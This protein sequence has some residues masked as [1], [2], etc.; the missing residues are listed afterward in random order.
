MKITTKIIWCLV[1]AFLAGTNTSVAA[2]FVV[3]LVQSPA[4]LAGYEGHLTACIAMM[5]ICGGQAVLCYRE[6][7]S[8]L[9]TLARLL[10]IA[11]GSDR[12]GA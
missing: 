2:I 4:E 3:G 1:F 9:R 5:L 8:E 11:Q 7:R 10:V 6:I 12:H